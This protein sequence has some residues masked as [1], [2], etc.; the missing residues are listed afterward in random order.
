M[1]EMDRD[2]VEC[3]TESTH[4]IQGNDERA[5]NTDVHIGKLYCVV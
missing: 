1:D 3:C 2:E 5:S 4:D